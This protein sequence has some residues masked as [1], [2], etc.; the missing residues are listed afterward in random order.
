MGMAQEA[1]TAA[2]RT[3]HA[4]SVEESLRA[5]EVDAAAGL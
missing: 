3:W 1:T 5:Q 2:P 4:L